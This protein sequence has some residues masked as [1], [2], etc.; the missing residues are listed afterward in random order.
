[1]DRIGL[2]PVMKFSIVT[3]CCNQNRYLESSMRSVLEQRIDDLEYIVIDGGSTDGSLETIRKHS[4]RLAY[5]E[6]RP[7]F[8]CMDALRA[9]FQQSGGE[10]MGWVHPGE[11]LAPWAM[12]VVERI[13]RSLPEVEWLTTLYPL[14]ID[15]DGLVTCAREM[16][17]YNADAFYRGRNAPLDPGFY[18]SAIR[19]ESTFW[20]R[21]LWERSGGRLEENL[22]TA[23]DFE[24]WARFFQ[25]AELYGVSV[26]LG[27]SRLQ[28]PSAPV[29]GWDSYLTECRTVL[30]RYSR[31]FPS[32][33]EAAVR[34]FLRLLPSRMYP[35]TGLAYRVMRIYSGKRC[36][37]W[38]I[39]PE[40]II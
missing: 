19:R 1:M 33:I 11:M 3:P 34:R 25:H 29:D 18:T 6:S 13:F 21:M 5:W 22:H 36:S 12:P 38:N 39:I 26:P 2:D 8:T 32:R 7:D 17:G 4:D 27:C 35:L 23:V 31:V 16:D 10:I 20:R 14:D 15:E 28:R 24:L 40:W 30:R 9:A 37:R